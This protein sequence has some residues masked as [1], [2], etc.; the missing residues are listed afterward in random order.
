MFTHLRAQP[1]QRNQIRRGRVQ[2]VR[3]ER[4]PVEHSERFA[5]PG[6]R[7]RQRRRT[8]LDA[9]RAGRGANEPR[10]GPGLPG[11]HWPV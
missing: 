7:L 5:G 6:R 9:E 11:T 4:R 8:L 3:D 10:H 1:M 2:P